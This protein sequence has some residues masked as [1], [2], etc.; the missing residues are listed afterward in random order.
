[1]YRYNKLYA[2]S[3]VSIAHIK[4]KFL[5]TKDEVQKRVDT[6]GD[7]EEDEVSSVGGLEEET[8][9]KV[10]EVG[11]IVK[12]CVYWFPSQFLLNWFGN[13]WL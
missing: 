1:M 9:P 10:Q 13:N 6:G 3:E 11:E 8:Y 12:S 5:I 4:R 7:S 2:D